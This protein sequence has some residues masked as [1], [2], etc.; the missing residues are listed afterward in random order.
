MAP[1][2]FVPAQRWIVALGLLLLTAVPMSHA[3]GPVW[4]LNL[5]S[6]PARSDGKVDTSKPSEKRA[7]WDPRRTAV[8]VVDMW[9]DHWCKGAARRVVELSGP[10]N[11]LLRQARADGAFILHAPS[12]T[13]RFYEDTP[14]RRAARTAPF[15]MAPV[16]LSTAER[17]GTKWCWPDPVRERELP[18][19]DS[20]MGCDC[21][22]KCTIREAWT[23]EIST[24]QI[25]PADAI[26]DDGQEAF[27]LL[28]AHHIDNVILLGVHLNMCVL[29]RPVGIR[30]LVTLGKNVALMR[31][32][33]DTMYNHERRPQVNHF[34]GTDLVVAHVESYWCPSFVSTDI[35]GRPAFR[36][37]EDSGSAAAH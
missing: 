24:L 28:Q 35:T 5:R 27:N 8:I 23:R 15:A 19:D 9:D 18:I 20:D 30:Q 2:F 16:P 31:D 7:T 33:T 26:T 14:Q 34:R 3:A 12:S 32:M 22:T 10:M 17:W 6:R 13:T 11:E 29:G 21:A 25:D 37:R 1:R 4:T 36:F